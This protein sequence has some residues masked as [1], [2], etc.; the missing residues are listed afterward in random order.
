MLN[1]LCHIMTWEGGPL[2]TCTSKS[3][4]IL[5]YKSLSYVLI[6]GENVLSLDFAQD[7]HGHRVVG[8]PSHVARAGQ[9]IE[10]LGE[11]LDGA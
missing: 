5:R 9:G 1:S 2:Y 3:G 6:H 11:I 8:V 4:A 7:V 10:E